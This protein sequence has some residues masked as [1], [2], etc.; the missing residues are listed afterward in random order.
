M[1]NMYNDPEELDGIL[2]GI[3]KTVKGQLSEEEDEEVLEIVLSLSEEAQELLD[4]LLAWPWDQKAYV[5][6][7]VREPS[8]YEALLEL[9]AKRLVYF[10]DE[11]VDDFWNEW[12][13]EAN[14]YLELDY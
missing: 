12:D 10:W 5:Q 9:R 14:M 4:R 2:V 11:Q 13:E 3:S 8:N 7:L 1:V 6:Y